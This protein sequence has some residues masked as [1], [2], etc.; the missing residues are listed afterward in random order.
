M[1]SSINK[2]ELKW[3]FGGYL[4]FSQTFLAGGSEVLESYDK[5][6]LSPMCQNTCK[7]ATNT[8]YKLLQLGSYLLVDPVLV[9]GPDGGHVRVEELRERA[10]LPARASANQTCLADCVVSNLKSEFKLEWVQLEYNEGLLFW[11]RLMLSIGWYNQFLKFSQRLFGSIQF[12][13]L[14]VYLVML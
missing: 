10:L 4:G 7:V 2:H 13:S 14:K 1:H 11:S 3:L 12:I 5:K 8:W 6:S 9:D